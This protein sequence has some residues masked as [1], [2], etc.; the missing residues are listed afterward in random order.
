MNPGCC[1]KQSSKIPKT[2]RET[3]ILFPNP[4]QPR[5][6]LLNYTPLSFILI[7][8][9][10]KITHFL[11]FLLQN[12]FS[13]RVP[14]LEGKGG[15]FPHISLLP[16]Y[17]SCPIN[18]FQHPNLYIVPIPSCLPGDSIRGDQPKDLPANSHQPPTTSVLHMPFNINFLF[19]ALPAGPSLCSSKTLSLSLLLFPG[20]EASHGAARGQ[21]HPA[22]PTIRLHQA[23]QHIFVNATIKHPHS[24]SK[25]L[26][27]KT[28]KDTKIAKLQTFSIQF[29]PNPQPFFHKKYAN[30]GAFINNK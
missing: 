19:K 16:Q 3:S 26:L 8:I 6:N 20:S 17:F 1:E 24:A 13:P 15:L 7:T 18:I 27:N 29:S 22:D 28:P 10:L 5:N 30:R 11:H 14:S 12:S 9:S 4:I 23:D 25:S 21:R 2:V